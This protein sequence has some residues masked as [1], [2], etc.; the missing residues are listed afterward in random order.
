MQRAKLVH[1]AAESKQ[2]ASGVVRLATPYFR[3]D[4]V[5]GSAAA[6]LRHDVVFR[7][8]VPGYTE[9]ADL[10]LVAKQENVLGLEVVV[11]N[12]SAF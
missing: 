12:F 2:I 11:D 9:V 10:D 1:D 6:R 8:E 3:S 4:V 7:S 5:V